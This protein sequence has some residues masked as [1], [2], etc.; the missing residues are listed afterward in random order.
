MADGKRKIASIN[1]ALRTEFVFF[2]NWYIYKVLFKNIWYSKTAGVQI[3][4]AWV[5][6]YLHIWESSDV[7]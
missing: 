7:P 5:G 3:T 6:F 2:L 4:P 1:G